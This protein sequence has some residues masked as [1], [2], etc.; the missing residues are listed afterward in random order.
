MKIETEH[1]AEKKIVGETHDKDPVYYIVTHGGLHC[2]FQKTKN[3][4]KTLAMAPH[5]AVARWMAEKSEP[6]IKWSEEIEKSEDLMKSDL[7]LY[8]ILLAYLATPVTTDFPKSPLYIAF[9]T[10]SSDM[11]LYKKE[12]LV[13]LPYDQKVNLI[14]RNVALDSSP[15]ILLKHKDFV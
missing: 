1:V 5:K 8:S 9:N 10:E 13:E 7:D 3:E 15:D 12:E 4:I 2:F 6:K 14:V 11:F